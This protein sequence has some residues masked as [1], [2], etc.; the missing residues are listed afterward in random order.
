MMRLAE[1][2][3]A[4]LDGREVDESEDEVGE[5]SLPAL[6]TFGDAGGMLTRARTGRVS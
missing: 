3:A 2:E 6:V 5:V 4:R 1:R